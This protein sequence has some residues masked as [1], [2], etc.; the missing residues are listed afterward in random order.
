MCILGKHIHP[1]MAECSVLQSI[2][3]SQSSHV[4]LT[5]HMSI[6]IFWSAY[7]TNEN[8]ELKSPITNMDFSIFPL[9]LSIFNS[10]I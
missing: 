7:S 4:A 8:G 2:R 5:F 10:C 3:S 6:L 9:V 1:G